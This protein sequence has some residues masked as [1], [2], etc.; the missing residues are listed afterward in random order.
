MA[1]PTLANA[2]RNATVTFTCRAEGGPSNTLTWTRLLDGETVST[3]GVLTILV[4][5]ATDGSDYECLVENDAGSE[6]VNI[7]LNGKFNLPKGNSV[8]H[9]RIILITIMPYFLQLPLQ[10]HFPPWLQM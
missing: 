2:E 6:T 7:T 9:C 10:F 8:S 1:F 3:D 5:S 4:D